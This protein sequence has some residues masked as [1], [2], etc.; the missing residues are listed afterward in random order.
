MAVDIES[1]VHEINSSNLFTLLLLRYLSAAI[2]ACAITVK[3]H[4]LSLI[5]SYTYISHVLQHANT[6]FHYLV[7]FFFKQ[8][9]LCQ[10]IYPVYNKSIPYFTSPFQ[11]QQRGDRYKDTSL[12]PHSRQSTITS[13][14]VKPSL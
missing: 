6:L 9:D 12:S 11:N 1:L 10:R 5:P 3:V 7:I 8:Q 14:P 4:S 13:K 2:S